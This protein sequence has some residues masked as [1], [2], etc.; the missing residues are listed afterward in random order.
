MLIV[1]K[2][3]QLSKDSAGKLRVKDE[4]YDSRSPITA[5]IH[6]RLFGGW[7]VNELSKTQYKELRRGSS[8]P[9]YLC[10]RALVW[11]WKLDG[12][13]IYKTTKMEDTL[14]A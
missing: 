4:S 8:Y 13:V 1:V 9:L 2:K 11:G 14:I 12:R 3:P 7:P 6:I 10:E 5:F